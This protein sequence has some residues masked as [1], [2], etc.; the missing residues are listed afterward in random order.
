[1]KK[2]LTDII[3]IIDQSGSMFGLQDDTVGGFNTFLN[4]QKNVDGEAKITTVLFNSSVTTLYERVDIKE[5]KPLTEKE[6]IPNG[7]TAMLDAIGISITKAGKAYSD[8]PDDERPSK[9][10]VM[11]TTDGKENCSSEYTH[12]QIKNMINH[13]KEKYNWEFVFTGANIDSRSTGNA[14]GL[15]NTANYS[16][17]GQG[18]QTVYTAMSKAATS[19]RT[20]GVVAT[21]W[22]SEI[23][24]DSINT[25][26]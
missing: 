5:V 6:Y 20:V 3:F 9:V 1:M 4:E 24:T 11:I 17:S 12:E 19:Y 15:S 22:S 2:D 8:L 25:N 14:I 18:I 26:E 21:D 23:V 13:Q 16:A 10:L 7:W